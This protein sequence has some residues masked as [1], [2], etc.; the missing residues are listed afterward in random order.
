MKKSVLFLISICSLCL[1][2]GCGGGGSV[3]PPPPPPPPPIPSSVP[4]VSQPLSP[5]A[6]VPGGAAFTLTVNGTGF[7][8]G[9]TVKWNGSARTTSFVSTSQLT[10]NIPATDI[11]N[12]N[13]ASVTVV[14]PTPG[15]GTS[16]AAFFETTR[17]TSSV[18][19]SITSALAT[20]TG[21]SS[22]ATEDFNG[23]GKLDLVVTNS[24]SNDI[25]V[26]LGKGDGTFQASV[27]YPAGTSPDSVAVGDFN[28]DAKLDLAVANHGSNDVSVFLGKGDGTFQAAVNYPAGTN[29]SSV[30]VGD[31]NGDGK[32]DLAVAN[33]GSLN[34]SVLLGN[35]DGTFQTAV[36]YGA[37]SNPSSVAVG[38]FNGDG[39]L[40]LAVAN[41]NSGGFG[42]GNGSILLGNG[43]GTF[44]ATVNYNAG[45]NPSSVAVGDFNGDGK[46]DLALANADIFNFG[47]G[48]IS[49]LLGNGDGTFKTAVDYGA[50]SNPSSVTVA[51]FNGD[52]KLDLAAT[53]GTSVGILLGNGDGTFQP[54]V[55]YAAGSSPSSLAVGDFNG[56]GR[57]D[58]AVADRASSTVS[59]LLQPGLSGPNATLAPTILTFAT[60]VVGTTSPVQS[61][62]LSNNGTATLNITSIAAST[63]FGESD[64]CGS[65]L[66]AGT[67]CNISVTFG[68]TAIDNLIG[69]LTITDSAPGS[70]QTVSL[71]GVGTVVKLIPASMSFQCTPLCGSQ[72]ATLTNTGATTLTIS[73]I[74]ITSNKASVN[75]RGGFAQTNNCTPSLGA[76]QSCSITVRFIGAFNFSYKGALNVNDN[77]GGGRQIVSLRGFAR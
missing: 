61:V 58:I 32:L 1:L 60:E 9:S 64:N 12:A 30:A 40:D 47:V 76:G 29:P 46:L 67:S 51:D 62:L 68:P 6:V 44:Q 59:V 11:A 24:G 23:D 77:G 18:S 72:A 53:N 21:P 52:G 15:G 20:G 14:N 17:P 75:D 25:S 10:A 42:N 73:N 43:D 22:V 39:K 45:T 71:N 63:N 31:F 49:I 8:S 57:L 36:D 41:A 55:D 54:P 33:F 66:A 7:V 35:G 19:W 48:G 56:D 16:N 3:S 26:F 74:T 2:N 65:S 34:V 4:F 37:G 27:N 38:D 5:A 50:G 28:G 69:T 70:P 13:T